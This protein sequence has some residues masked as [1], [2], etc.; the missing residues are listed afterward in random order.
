LWKGDILKQAPK[1][2][3]LIIPFVC[4]LCLLL[5]QCVH[6]PAFPPISTEELN[7]IEHLRV[8]LVMD[9]RSLGIEHFAA[10]QEA[11]KKGDFAL[12]YHHWSKASRMTK[13]W[14]LPLLQMALLHPFYDNDQLA[15]ISELKQAVVINPRNPRSQLMLGVAYEQLKQ[16]DAAST[17]MKNAIALN[18]KY[19]EAHLRLGNL[20]R[21]SG[22]PKEAIGAYE[23]I[24]ILQPKNAMILSILAI[25]YEE[26]SNLEYAESSLRRLVIL[27][28]KPAYAFYKLARFY[29][30]RGRIEEAQQAFERAEELNP[31][32]QKRKMRPLLPSIR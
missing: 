7:E 21:N 15:Q 25:L 8:R 3:F 19:V 6:K 13:D 10:G 2:I 26:I 32:T 16:F 28:D 18:S 5:I 17:H 30:R 12:A 14:D 27:H 22:M 24:T 1:P 29:E 9:A 11:F 4:F 23:Q 31:L 20:Y